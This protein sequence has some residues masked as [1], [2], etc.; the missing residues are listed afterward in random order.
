MT[1]SGERCAEATVIS[2]G[3]AQLFQRCRPPPASPAR[4]SRIPSESER[5]CRSCR[6]ACLAPSRRCR[7][8]SACPSNA[9][10]RRRRRRRASIAD[11][12]V[13][14]RPTTVSTR[15][16]AVTIVPS[17]SAVPEWKTVTSG[18]RRRLRRGRRDRRPGRRP[19]RDIPP[20]PARRRR[21]LSRLKRDR[22]VVEPA[23]RAP[24]P[25]A[26]RA[27]RRSR[28]ARPVP[29]DRRSR[30]LNSITFGP[31]HGQ[32]QAR[33]RESRGTR[34]PRCAVPRSTGS[35]ISR[36][37]RAC[38][39]VVEQRARR[40]RAHAAG[41]RPAIVVEDALVI[42]RPSASGTARV[43]SQSAK[44][45]TSRTGQALLEHERARRRRRTCR[46]SSPRAPRASAS[47]R[48]GATTTPLPAAR[49][50][51]FTHDREAEL[52]ARD[53]RVR[54]RGRLADAIARRRN[55]VSRHEVLREHLAALELRRR[56]RGPEHQPAPA[57]NR[58]TMPRS[59]GSSGPT[60]VRSM[61]SRC[62]DRPAPPAGP[63][64]STGRRVATRACRDCRA[65]RSPR[66]H[67]RS[68]ASFHASAC[69]RPPL[70]TTRTLIE[71]GVATNAG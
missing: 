29:R 27:R 1:R 48:S 11:S 53:D 63:P 24:Q 43:P 41:V 46:P 62:G 23:G 45:D 33:R 59:S 3:D 49:P 65:R 50:S 10:A 21:S 15:P 25:D 56:A 20:T 68:E 64:A 54:L 71:L 36:I 40:E 8:G 7:A 38:S 28:A 58:S 51:A 31:S 70:P 55:P 52:A 19:L 17:R 57:A 69:S 66:R 2:L 44:N 35:T 37:T 32:H 47:A 61:R 12:N 60:T 42:L 5:S 22:R 4:R 6:T 30:T 34:C 9:D 18:E 26:A 67:P 13:A 39:R 14:P 16:P